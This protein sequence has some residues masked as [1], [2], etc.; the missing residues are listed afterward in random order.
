MWSMCQHAHAFQFIEFHR[1]WCKNQFEMKK[2]HSAIAVS[3]DQHERNNLTTLTKND[4]EIKARKIFLLFLSFVYVK[5]N[6]IHLVSSLWVK[7]KER[8][9]WNPY[10]TN[11]YEKSSNTSTVFICFA[12]FLGSIFVS[13]RFSW[14]NLALIILIFDPYRSKIFKLSV[15]NIFHLSSIKFFHF[16]CPVIKRLWIY[17]IFSFLTVSLSIDLLVYNHFPCMRFIQQR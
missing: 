1:I 13:T 7:R 15:N 4:C 5:R 10:R 16:V 17:L 8:W 11:C 14:L 9:S 12:L 6:K 3:H 2:T